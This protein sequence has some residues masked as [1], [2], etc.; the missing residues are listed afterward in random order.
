MK[1]FDL[2]EMKVYPYEERQ[3][4][5]FYQTNEF[6]TIIVELPPGGEIPKCEMIPY[7][8]F[9]VIKGSAEIKVNEEKV[10]LRE[11]QCL[12]TEPA[13]LSMKTDTGV[14]IMGTQIFKR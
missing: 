9:T 8:I 3:K 12:I 10:T 13:T 1:V 6:K 11:G 14:K 2:K 4:N 5:I 7:V